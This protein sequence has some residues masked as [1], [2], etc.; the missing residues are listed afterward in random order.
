MKR[1]ENL[2]PGL[3]APRT[4]NFNPVNHKKPSWVGELPL[5]DDASIAFSDETYRRRAQALAGVNEMIHELLDILEAE[6][7]KRP[8]AYI[9][10]GL[11]DKFSEEL[12]IS[13]GQ[14]NY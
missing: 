12:V 11:G 8:L 7:E 14:V 3:K 10:M 1:H 2:Y 6:G 9:F 13:I 4:P 5:M